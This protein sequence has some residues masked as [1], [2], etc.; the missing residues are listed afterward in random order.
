MSPMWICVAGPCGGVSGPDSYSF[1]GRTYTGFRLEVSVSEDPFGA[2]VP[3]PVGVPQAQVRIVVECAGDSR[4]CPAGVLAETQGPWPATLE[5]SGFRIADPDLLVFKVE[6]LGP[7]PRPVNGSGQ[8]F[9]FEGTL[10]SVEGSEADGE[11]EGES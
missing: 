4:T 1:D 10:T 5:A 6:Y 7:Y 9:D 3:Y 8:G 11:D 2:G